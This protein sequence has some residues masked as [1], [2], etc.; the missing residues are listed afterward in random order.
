MGASRQQVPQLDPAA[1]ETVPRGPELYSG[2]SHGNQA[3]LEETVGRSQPACVGPSGLS[4]G[5]EHELYLAIFHAAVR[6]EAHERLDD[7]EQ[8]LSDLGDRYG[9]VSGSSEAWE[10]LREAAGRVA[11]L[12]GLITAEADQVRQQGA[13]APQLGALLG[14]EALA[15][16]QESAAA[17]Q[18]QL[19][20]LRERRGELFRAAPEL[21]L[22][23]AAD[24]G[25]ERSDAELFGGLVPRVAEVRGFI[26]DTRARI[27]SGDLALHELG[28]LLDATQQALGIDEA[29]RAAG[30]PLSVAALS[31]RDQVQLQEAVL[32]WSG[33]LLSFT[34]G[35]AAAFA[36]G[37][38]AVLLGLLGAGAGLAGGARE[39]E[40]AIDGYGAARAG[41]GG[42]DIAGST[43]RARLRL[44]LASL[45]LVLGAADVG[46]AARAMTRMALPAQTLDAQAARLRSAKAGVTTAEDLARDAAEG[47][48]PRFVVRLVPTRAEAP[49]STLDAAFGRGDRPF[50]FFSR[51]DDLAGYDG[52]AADALRAVGWDEESITGFAR[53][54][55]V[56]AIVID[57]HELPLT[58]SVAEIRWADVH[59]AIA[60]DLED[61]GAGLHKTLDAA[62]LDSE[63]F[64]LRSRQIE[65]LGPD[66]PIPPELETTAEVLRKAYGLNGLYG[67]RGV[68]LSDAAAA[69]VAREYAVQPVNGADVPDTAWTV[70]TLGKVE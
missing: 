35:V 30:D 28:P 38:T 64:H 8:A 43:D 56:H 11:E 13:Y 53:G 65:A 10:L 24:V 61:P 52:C 12:D 17:G 4:P 45:D 51:V 58:G 70:V 63:T 21:A 69:P 47:G 18:V 42:Q 5:Q 1:R 41:E 54:R 62:G 46:L 34:L 2:A 48:V 7:N 25:P 37:G 14:P 20:L 40:G 23:D 31:W 16:S 3:A 39:L 66:S 32:S 55:Y 33:P 15:D 50:Y 6:T 49:P 68:T 9:D 19:A 26:D 36:S 29:A 67:G 60:N 59:R 44:V 27:E 22:F 57:T